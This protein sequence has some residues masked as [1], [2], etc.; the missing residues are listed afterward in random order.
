MSLLFFVSYANAQTVALPDVNLRNKLI[1]NYPQVMQGNELDIAEAAALHGML[2]LANSNISN[3]DGIQYFTS[4]TTLR[5]SGNQLSTIPD[6][7]GITGLVN[8][9]ASENQLTILK[10]LIFLGTFRVKLLMQRIK[11]K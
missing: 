9:Y 10:V 2:D 3:A 8:F 1:A 7:S 4:I 11:I 5:L 6:I